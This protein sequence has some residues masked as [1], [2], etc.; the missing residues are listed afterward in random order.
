MN[1]S[2]FTI[3]NF[4][5]F[6]EEQTLA[7]AVPISKKIGSGITYIVGANNSGKTTLLESLGIDDGRYLLEGEIKL[8]PRFALYQEERIAKEV[9]ITECGAPR[10]EEIHKY[11]HNNDL[12]EV[13]SS[14]RHWNAIGNGDYTYQEIVKTLI[15]LRENQFIKTAALLKNINSD[16]ARYDSFTKLVKTIIPEF[17]KWTVEIEDYPDPHSRFCI[18]YVSS[19]GITHSSDFL[20]DGVTSVIR[21]L[22]HLFE[23][24][25]CGLIIDEPELSLHPLAQKKLIALIAKYAKERQ[26]ILSTHSPYFIKWEYIKNGAKLN[27]VAKTS[28][29]SSKIHTLQSPTLYDSLI[30]GA[31]WQQPFLMDEVAK[32]IFFANDNILFLEGQEDVGLLREK[33]PKDVHL[34]GYG[35][36]GYANFKYA[37][38]MAKDLGFKKVGV[39]LDNGEKESEHF[40]KLKEIFCNGVCD[41]KIIQWNKNDIRDKEKISKE[42]KIGY[43]TK[44]GELKSAEQLDDFEAKIKEIIEYYNL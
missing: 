40:S 12:F 44:D 33:L 41:Y 39:I 1:Y 18:N 2:K 25:S 43:F 3:E 21:I 30:K 6:A 4:R 5:C 36:R 8:L 22:A 26:I 19:N 7:F 15:P 20:G 14:K 37:L 31:N 29:D 42:G 28:N 17:T 9:S 35:V 23:E 16:T 34:F 11:E 27:R 38:A 10:F 24:R 13:I 32:E